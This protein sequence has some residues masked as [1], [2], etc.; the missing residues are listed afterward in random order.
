MTLNKEILQ[1]AR[2]GDDPILKKEL[3]QSAQF[4]RNLL[5]FTVPPKSA[6]GKISGLLFWLIWLLSF[7]FVTYSI[8][9]VQC[10]RTNER[11]CPLPFDPHTQIEQADVLWQKSREHSQSLHEKYKP[12]VLE[13]YERTK[14][15]FEPL[16]IQSLKPLEPAW[17]QV[18]LL[19]AESD[20][21]MKAFK[22]T[23][24][25]DSSLN[26]TKHLFNLSTR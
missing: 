23:I 8:V 10:E 4:I 14:T 22:K 24:Q 5:P 11:V 21:R 18:L 6:L 1:Q 9:Y 20:L 3:V 16:V 19:K 25:W 17:Q 7:S 13:Q 26:G 15:Q 12:V 2:Q